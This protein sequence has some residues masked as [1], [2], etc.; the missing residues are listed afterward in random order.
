MLFIHTREGLWVVSSAILWAIICDTQG[1]VLI[2]A[3]W[4]I[5]ISIVTTIVKSNFLEAKLKADAQGGNIINIVGKIE[6][7]PP[8]SC[9]SIH[10]CSLFQNPF[11]GCFHTQEDLLHLL[12]GIFTR[13]VHHLCHVDMSQCVL[14][15][16][17]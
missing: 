10:P 14:V 2:C 9:L 1:K 7:F 16:L 11:Q 4:L 13:P 15:H 6:N 17:T 5:S 12:R 8:V 3:H